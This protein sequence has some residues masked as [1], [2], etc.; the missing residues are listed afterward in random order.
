MA[1]SQQ[2]LGKYNRII[3]MAE[4]YRDLKQELEEV[5]EKLSAPDIDID[6]AVELKKQAEKLIKKLQKYL[7]DIDTKDD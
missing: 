4:K 6:E 2:R 3:V 1:L 5:V 7:D